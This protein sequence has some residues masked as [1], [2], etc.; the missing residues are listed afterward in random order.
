MTEF[1]KLT[2]ALDT[3]LEPLLSKLF[4][5]PGDSEAPVYEIQHQHAALS[6]LLTA[7]PP[8]QERFNKMMSR[9]RETNPERQVFNE[10][11][12]KSMEEL[13]SRFCRILGVLYEWEVRS[14]AEQ[15]TGEGSASDS[16]EASSSEE[17]E[18]DGDDEGATPIPTWSSVDSLQ[19]WLDSDDV[20]DAMKAVESWELGPLMEQ[21]EL[22]YAKHVVEQA[23]QEAWGNE[24]AATLV[25]TLDH[26]QGSRLVITSTEHADRKV[27]H[28]AYMASRKGARD[29]QE[30]RE[31]AIW[32]AEVARREAEAASLEERSGTHDGFEVAANRIKALNPPRTGIVILKAILELLNEIIFRPENPNVRTI[33]NASKNFISTFGHPCVAPG[34]DIFYAVETMLGSC[35]FQIRYSKKGTLRSKEVMG[36]CAPYRSATAA[37]S[38]FLSVPVG[39]WGAENPAVPTYTPLG[40]E[41]YGER[42][43]ELKEP[44]AVDEPDEWC[45]WHEG[46][47][48]RVAILKAL[49]Q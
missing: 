11:T 48:S 32:A 19:Q 8:L 45:T 44:S 27:L 10:K 5:Q 23:A 14:K 29:A 9:A 21:V 13:Y 17:S 28:D 38:G 34:Q 22:Q 31:A 49:K 47:L 36:V 25:G 35:G 7:L 4:P 16:G 39:D 1:K 46:M 43:L 3:E 41:E 37:A 6:T 18:G 2:A 20:P 24:V 15:A 42:L 26:E 12:C 40:Y 33:R 30:A